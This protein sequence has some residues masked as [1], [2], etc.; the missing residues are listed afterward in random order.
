MQHPV[1]VSV[2][3]HHSIGRSK[4]FNKHRNPV[5]LEFLGLVGFGF[6]GRRRPNCRSAT[7]PNHF[8]IDFCPVPSEWT[9][10][11]RFS[12][13]SDGGKVVTFRTVRW[14]EV[15]LTD[16]RESLSR[17]RSCVRSS[18][19]RRSFLAVSSGSWRRSAG[20]LSAFLGYELLTR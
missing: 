16:D 6:G 11:N 14:T 2:T 13:L 1:R 9:A 19:A 5:E 8:T 20:T 17:R 12:Y 18:L 7:N 15:T 4:G 10:R 3:I